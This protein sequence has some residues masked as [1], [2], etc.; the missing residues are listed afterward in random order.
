L[1]AVPVGA[2]LDAGD[3]AVLGCASVAELSAA[4]GTTTASALGEEAGVEEEEEKAT[5]STGVSSGRLS[6]SE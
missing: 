1:E 5:G 6:A 2:A 3:A 4:T